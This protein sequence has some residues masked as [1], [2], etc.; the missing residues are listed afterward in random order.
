MRPIKLTIKGLNSF[1]EQQTIDFEKLTEAGLFG[2]FGPTGSGKS[3][4]L[5]GITLALYGDVARKSTNYIN[6]NCND[7]NVSYEF[8]I[9]GAENHIYK[10]TR[11]L[12][13]DKKTGNAKTHSASVIEC[14]NEP[15]R[16]IAEGAMQ[17]T[18]ACKEIIGLGLEDFTRTVVLPQGKFSEFLKLEG[19]SRREML[20]RLFNLQQYGEQLNIK[21]SREVGKQKAK[22]NQIIGELK[23]YENLSEEKLTQGKDALAQS[24][25]QL[26]QVKQEQK[27]LEEVYK[28]NEEVWHLQQELQGYYKKQQAQE[29][30]KPEIEKEELQVIRGESAQRISP[31]LDAYEMTHKKLIEEEENLKGVHI[32][33][34]I[35]KERKENA[36]LDF[37][38]AERNRNDKLPILKEYQLSLQTALEEQAEVVAAEER[39]KK[40]FAGLRKLEGSMN[41]VE[42]QQ[43]EVEKAV[44]NLT[45]QI[46]YKQKEEQSLKVEEKERA[47]IQKGLVLAQREAVQSQTLEA[48][49]TTQ[50][51]LALKQ[52]QRAEALKVQ[53]QKLEARIKELENTQKSYDEMKVPPIT[54]EQLMQKQEELTQLTEQQKRYTQLLSEIE[55]AESKNKILHREEEKLLKETTEQ[56]ALLEQAEAELEKAKMEYMV[57]TLSMRLN[58]GDTC[59]VCGGVIH[60]FA[61][62]LEQADETIKPLEQQVEK[63]QFDYQKKEK[64]KNKKQ[65]EKLANTQ[66]LEH[67]KQ[68]VETLRGQLETAQIEEKSKVL[69][70]LNIQ[71]KEYTTK[72]NQLEEILNKAKEDKALIEKTVTEAETTFIEGEKQNQQ[73][74]KQIQ[75][76]QK[77]VSETRKDLEEIRK[78]LSETAQGLGSIAFDTLNALLQDKDAKREVVLKQ[79]NTFAQ[80][81]ENYLVQKEAL[82][83]KINRYKAN[84]QVGLAQFDEQQK[85]KQLALSKLGG[86]LSIILSGLKEENY[87]LV[88]CKSQL[89]VLLKENPLLEQALAGKQQVQASIN[90]M[91]EKQTITLDHLLDEAPLLQEVLKDLEVLM[92]RL[93]SL[94]KVA[95]LQI[96][97][98]YIQK[99][100]VYQTT[101]K[102][103][104][105][106]IKA[107]LELTARI[108]EMK[109]R[110]QEEKQ[111][112]EKNLTA[113]ALT[114]E[115]V[116]DY[117]LPKE[118]LI[119]LKKHINVY[120]ETCSK[121]MGAMEH[122]TKKLADRRLT[123]EVW[124]QSKLELEQVLKKVEEQNE[125]V[126][127][128][129]EYVKNVE[130]A[131]EKL[132][133]LSKEKEAVEHRL[134]ILGDLEK[135]FKGKRFVEYVAS[136]RLKYI[137]MEAS[138]RLQE[139]TCGNYGME[140]DPEGRF[141]MRDYKNGGAERDAST[142]SGG[143]TFL[144]SL[145]LALALSAE[146]QLK[147]TAPLELF[148][149]DEGFGTLDDE[150]LDVVMSSLER[151]HHDKLKIGIISHVEAIKNRVP[152]KLILTPAESG[153]GGTKV[154]LERS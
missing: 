17:V 73:L 142:L 72:K 150:L 90:S 113:E 100:K 136:T 143:E 126:I 46:A 12:K 86:R 88:A 15:E 64:D 115:E 13:R 131:L 108:E 33:S 57:Y 83:N 68:E 29:A 41:G 21:L 19:K 22:N 66:T 77:M 4:V 120:K 69:E 61:G 42:Q 24:Q 25:K 37:V 52:K 127:K 32:Q 98:D 1:I 67:I 146:I 107:L 105:E 23:G 50:S 26:K 121:L 27:Q 71:L 70:S 133:E 119:E 106:T 48:Y 103:Y 147:G 7:L 99:Q 5:D 56:K 85:N 92:K 65:L 81:K 130:A 117:L 137:S 79:M 28:Q 20:E 123:E 89:V 40:I 116:K 128:L 135:L 30:M 109:K 62:K 97:E 54:Q 145:A 8:Q 148:F 153:K 110:Q 151:I 75:L 2:I 34:E 47:C 49:K 76:Q 58:K 10:V 53:K 138:K 74:T 125:Q 84:F 139:I 44:E 59:P 51:E 129:T 91:Q 118:R 11:H 96:E 3:T 154:K 39:I 63:I 36:D 95:I 9:S 45:M 14:T 132:G 152:I 134:A 55:L 16:V 18:K 82:Q 144:A 31:S 93:S 149:L 87:D 60:E 101:T 140:V 35:L 111:L 124:Q 80:D 94:L 112:L 78:D 38:S 122:A 43:I 104:E 114:I 102:Q 6:I 141:I